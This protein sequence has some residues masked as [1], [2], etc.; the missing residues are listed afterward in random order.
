MIKKKKQSVFKKSRT[1]E[2][3]NINRL[4]GTSCF[5]AH[6]SNILK[7]ELLWLCPKVLDGYTY[8][9]VF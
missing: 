8:L 5:N 1:R 4:Q 3:A 6:V 2:T 7:F 9:K